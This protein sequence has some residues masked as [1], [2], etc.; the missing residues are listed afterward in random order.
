M[1]PYTLSSGPESGLCNQLYALAGYVMGVQRRRHGVLIGGRLYAVKR[2]K[3]RFRMETMVM[4]NMTSHDQN[5]RNVEFGDLFDFDF[6]RETMARELNITILRRLGTRNAT[7][8]RPLPL[9]GWASWKSFRRDRE[10]L[11]LSRHK[12]HPNQYIEDAVFSGLRPSK[13]ME[14]RIQ[15]AQ[16]A[17]SLGEHY[18]CLHARVEFDMLASWRQTH[19][20]PAP[21]LGQY[22]RHVPSELRATRDV[23]VAIGVAI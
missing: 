18:G 12:E 17:A 7:V 23:F 5:G 20:G 10:R 8:E 4:P 6:F 1:W 11:W 16:A 9:S 13:A 15:A 14:R 19:V 3:K 22:L 21:T 2:Q